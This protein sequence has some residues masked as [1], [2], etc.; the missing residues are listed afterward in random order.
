MAQKGREGM[1]KRARERAR[2]ERQEAKKLRRDALT[3]EARMA[4][5]PDTEGLMEEF[6]LLSERYAA[7][8]VSESHY[9]EERRRI[10]TL[11]GIEDPED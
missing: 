10:L 8:T 2:E 3:D 5:E 9:Q 7:K 1:A 11:L 4:T 6:R